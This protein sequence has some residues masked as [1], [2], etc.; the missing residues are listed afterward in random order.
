MSA[1]VSNIVVLRPGALGDVLVVRELLC[2]LKRMF[3]G[4]PVT[5][6][7]A[8]RRGELL[9]QPGLADACMDWDNAAFSW[10]FSSD[11]V[12]TP[13]EALVS[14]FQNNSLVLAYLDLC[15]KQAVAFQQRLSALA[16]P[17]FLYLSPSRPDSGEEMFIG[18]WLVHK[19]RRYCEAQQLRMTDRRVKGRPQDVFI[20]VPDNKPDTGMLVLHPGSGSARKNWPLDRFKE[21]GERFLR[22]DS[23]LIR[24]ICIL[25][26][27]ADGCLGFELASALPVAEHLHQPELPEVAYCLGNASLYLGNDSGISHLAASVQTTDGYQPRV[28]VLFGPSDSSIW[29]QPRA[30]V[31]QCGQGMDILSSADV[32][33]QMKR[34]WYAGQV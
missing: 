7:A 33:E 15:G 21:V 23:S 26:G 3:P 32:Y 20:T 10:L 18:S 13:P 6:A 14:L 29:G 28:T 30:L 34:H 2:W 25:S 31:L 5:L 12:Q 9:R 4:V 11:S 19:A 24:K 1:T 8:G 17:L 16:S 27:D 22:E